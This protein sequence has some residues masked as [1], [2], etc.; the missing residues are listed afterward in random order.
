MV[1]KVSSPD[2]EYQHPLGNV[3]EVHIIGSSPDLV[4]QRL[5]VGPSNLCLKELYG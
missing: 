1:L 2:Q 3:L 4:N 5:R